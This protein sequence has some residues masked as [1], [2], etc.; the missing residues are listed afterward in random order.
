M[1]EVAH[2]LQTQATSRAGQERDLFARSAYNRYYY[3]VFLTIRDS[4]SNMND[5]WETRKHKEIPNKLRTTIYKAFQNE[6]RKAASQ[7]DYELTEIIRKA[8][9][10]LCELSALLEKAEAARIVADYYPETPVDFASAERF[11]LAKIDITEA[12]QWKEQ[13]NQHIRT[14][15]SAWMQ[16]N[17]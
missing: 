6:K 7:R 4:L 15:Q 16:V 12:H 13:V 17:A 2:H 8:Q 11:S 5:D 9:A 1:Q 14:I 3:G 10:S